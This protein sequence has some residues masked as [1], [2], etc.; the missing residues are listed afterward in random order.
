MRNGM[1]MGP[2]K[3]LCPGLQT[4]PYDFDGYQ[5][6]SKILYD[7][8]A[9]FTHDIEAVSCDEMFVDCTDLLADTG[10][11]ATEVAELLRQE[12][13]EATD[14]NASVGIGEIYQRNFAET[15]DLYLHRVPTETGKPGNPGK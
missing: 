14:C 13:R 9:S 10:A 11:T 15:H 1:F 3:A 12:I 6:V 2:A 8:V 7:T 4:I 5:Q